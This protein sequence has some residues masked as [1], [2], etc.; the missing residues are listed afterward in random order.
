MWHKVQQVFNRNP[1]RLTVYL[2]FAQFNSN[3]PDPRN[4]KQ[5]NLVNKFTKQ[6]VVHG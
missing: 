6:G 1:V 2:G 3:E 5:V 4:F